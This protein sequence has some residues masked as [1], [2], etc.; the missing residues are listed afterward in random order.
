MLHT[1][2]LQKDTMRL[3]QAYQ[4]RESM[5]TPGD[6][7]NGIL[8]AITALMD[9]EKRGDI[10][11]TYG[12]AKNDITDFSLEKEFRAAAE[13]KTTS[14]TVY[15]TITNIQRALLTDIHQFLI[16]QEILG[17]NSTSEDAVDIAARFAHDLLDRL[18][19][20]KKSLGVRNKRDGLIGRR[21][22]GFNC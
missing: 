22:A 12:K 3:L 8:F 2:T 10:L 5:E 17:K 11:V 13:K 7:F 1:I 16:S 14:E 21:I 15:A 19:D 20:G 6:A 18:Q 9:D 4:G